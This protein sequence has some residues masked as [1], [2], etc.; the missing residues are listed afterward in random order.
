MMLAAHSLASASSLRFEPMREEDVA[1]VAALE[2]RAHRFPWTPG[3]FTDSLRAGHSA[4]LLREGS[5]LVGYGIVMMTVD[6]AELL[7]ITVAPEHHRR[8]LGAALLNYLMAIAQHHGARRMVLEVR[9][10]NAAGLG[11]YE[12]RGFARI[13]CRKGYYRGAEDAIVMAR[14]L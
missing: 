11:L 4:W 9:A 3:N 1:D 10:G 6:E 13:G 2:Q 7:D 8:G 5:N 14:S 12:R